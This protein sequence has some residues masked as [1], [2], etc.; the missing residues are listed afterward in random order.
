MSSPHPGWPW[1]IRFRASIGCLLCV[2]LVHMRRLQKW[3]NRKQPVWISGNTVK[4][5]KNGA[6]IFP[7]M[8][9]AIEQAAETIHLEMYI[10][11]SDQVGWR[12]AEALSRKAKE[13]VAVKLI[14]D[15]LG[16][17]TSSRELFLTMEKAGVE[18]F[19]Y[20]P[21]APWNPGWRLRKRDHRKILVI[22]GRCGFVGGIN[23]GNEYADSSDGGEG[24]R[25][26]HIRLEGPAVRELQQIFLSTW[27]KNKRAKLGPHPSYYPDLQPSGD[28]PVSL[29]ASQ[30]MKGKN[31][32]KQAYLDAIRQAEKQICITNS[33]FVPPPSVLRELKLAARRGVQVFIM[34][35]KKSDVQI[36]DYARR[37]L[38]A[39]LL[40]WGVRIFELEGPI[41]HAKTAVI[42]GK[43]STVGSY[44]MDQLSFSYNLEVNVV[45]K[46]RAFGNEMET[47]F[48]ADL[49]Q[50]S[51]VLAKE[52]THRNLFQ[53]MLEN[54]SYYILAWF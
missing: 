28:L 40:R 49:K 18:I 27:V 14:Y 13:G 45:V 48:W 20:H 7:E 46:G 8:L 30:G 22:D 42:D 54:T 51:E 47:M 26:T 1:V 25:D 35:P 23:L 15:S 10:F 12:F 6:Q 50:S 16:S 3:L 4:I 39:K 32:I 53:K 37:A 34:V 31:Q 11:R 19:E 52:W 24:W 44:N 5:L 33:Y 41:L 43:W 21:I 38:Y 36:I 9:L 2:K 17:L 29:L